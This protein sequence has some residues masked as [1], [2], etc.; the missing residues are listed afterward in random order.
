MRVTLESTPEITTLDGIRGR[1]WNGETADGIPV[2]AL[3]ARIA[4]PHEQAAQF[5]AELVA[6]AEPVESPRLPEGLE[7]KTLDAYVAFASRFGEQPFDVMSEGI[8]WLSVCGALSL[9]LRHPGY[10]GPSSHI[11][12]EFVHQLVVRFV[13][14]GA[15]PEAFEE[16]A[17]G[18][19]S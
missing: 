5:D 11:V 17:P 9:A 3:I 7:L 18:C 1:I 15:P 16:F 4:A 2:T 13:D 6:V 19:Q 10:R 14:Q 8:V 12:R